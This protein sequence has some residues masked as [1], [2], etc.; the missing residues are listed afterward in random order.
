MKIKIILLP[1]LLAMSV[2]AMENKDIH[3]YED[4]SFKQGNTEYLKSFC[5]LN[6]KTRLCNEFS[7]KSQREPERGGI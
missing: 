3:Y 1:L 7:V 4:D 2:R 6:L 5:T